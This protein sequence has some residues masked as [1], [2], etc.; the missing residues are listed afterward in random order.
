MPNYIAG[1]VRNPDHATSVQAAVSLGPKLRELQ[2]K[3][4]EAVRDHG[5]VNDWD[6][7]NMSSFSSYG[8]STIR[9]RR[10]ELYHAGLLVKVGTKANP[11]G[12]SMT[13]W[14]VHP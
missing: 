2:Q 1:M 5:P 9:K 8:P 12:R 6:L 3:V 4:L 10:S 14:G 11:N 7:E 13:L